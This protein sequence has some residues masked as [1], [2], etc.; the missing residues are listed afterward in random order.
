MLTS[1]IDRSSRRHE[2]GGRVGQ[3]DVAGITEPSSIE[4]RL[5]AGKAKACSSSGQIL[6]A[7]GS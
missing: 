3:T 5:I 2:A 6:T 7:N 1:P 4:N